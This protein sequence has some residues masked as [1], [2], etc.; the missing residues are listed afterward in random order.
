M[1]YSGWSGSG[2]LVVG[3]AFVFRL[4]YPL[5]C[6]SVFHVVCLVYYY[7]KYYCYYSIITVLYIMIIEI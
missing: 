6:F 5:V 4:D 7:S 1:P 2:S 3:L